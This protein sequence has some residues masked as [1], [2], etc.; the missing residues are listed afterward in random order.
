MTQVLVTIVAPVNS[1]KLKI[2]PDMI[3]KLE[4][5]AVSNIEQG[6]QQ[7]DNDGESGVHF[8]SLHAIPAGDGRNGYLIFEFSADGG[9]EQALERFDR[10]IRASLAEV[11]AQS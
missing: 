7:L 1:E 5:R 10:T 9:Q 2:L 8:A 4:N 11:F 6:L 3:D